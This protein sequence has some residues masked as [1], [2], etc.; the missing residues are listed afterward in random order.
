MSSYRV[1]LMLNVV[2]LKLFWMLSCRVSLSW[3]SYFYSH[4][5]C[6]RA[7]C[8][9]AEYR[10]FIAMQIVV[11]PRVIL[12]NIVAAFL[13]K[14]KFLLFNLFLFWWKK[15]K[16][17]EYSALARVANTSPFNRTNSTNFYLCNLQF[18]LIGYCVYQ[19][20]GSIFVT[21]NEP[22]SAFHLTYS[23]L[24]TDI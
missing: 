11:V 10:I 5:Q 23:C 9:F 6:C 3:M 22:L 18:R 8:H 17:Y 24:S 19:L 14:K 1:P 4:A 21:V 12:L 16:H 13:N 20:H 2:F 15:R 7:E